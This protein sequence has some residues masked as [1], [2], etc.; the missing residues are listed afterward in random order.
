MARKEC[1]VRPLIDYHGVSKSTYYDKRRTLRNQEKDTKSVK[2]IKK[3]CTRRKFKIGIRQIKLELEYQHKIVI[4]KKK[5]E[6]IKRQ[7]QIPTIIRRKNKYRAVSKDLS[8]HST[9]KN[10]LNREFKVESPD[11]VYC[12]DVTQINLKKEKVFLSAAKDLCSK[13]IVA[14]EVSKRN[15]LSLTNKTIDKALRKLDKDQMKRLMIHS[16]QGFNYTH[17][18]FRDK[19]LKAGVTQSMSRKGNCIDNSPIE[20]F[21]GVIKDHIDVKSCD[22]FEELKVE[23]YKQIKYYNENRPQIRLKKLPP[24]EYRRLFNS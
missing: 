21:F 13:D 18:S 20:S 4:N 2:L 17:F 23:I 5:I 1:R 15:D 6:R 24:S 7:Y 3:L 11:E 16:D 9:S 19:L 22:T 14:I 10:I 8:E 12:T